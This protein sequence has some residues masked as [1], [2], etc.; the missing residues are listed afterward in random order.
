MHKQGGKAY[1]CKDCA[2]ADKMKKTAL[3][4][5]IEKY[6][7]KSEKGSYKD[8]IKELP[9]FSGMFGN[10]FCFNTK[11]QASKALAIAEQAVNFL[12]W[13]VERHDDGFMV[14]SRG[15]DKEASVLK[16]MLNKYANDPYKGDPGFRHELEDLGQEH[17]FLGEDYG[18]DLGKDFD[19]GTLGHRDT[20]NPYGYNTLEGV[21]WDEGYDAGFSDA[22]HSMR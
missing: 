19:D 4:D 1:C 16:S 17:G 12:N 9:G 10:G 5:M 21:A 3:D 22:S 11:E 8:A 20:E 13:K 2:K 18:Q 15:K 6:A 7:G 14:I